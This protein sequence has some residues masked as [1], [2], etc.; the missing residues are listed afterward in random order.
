MISMVAFQRWH[1]TLRWLRHDWRQADSIP[2]RHQLTTVDP[3]RHQLLLLIEHLSPTP[4]EHSTETFLTEFVFVTDLRTA[5]VIS[6]AHACSISQIV[7]NAVFFCQGVRNRTPRKS[8]PPLPGV[9]KF[10][11]VFELERLMLPPRGAKILF[12]RCHH[13]YHTIAAPM[14]SVFFLDFFFFVV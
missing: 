10:V 4:E 1:A 5:L 2:S 14:L 9:R 12:L 11:Q 13:K 8:D 6:K 7:K 3:L